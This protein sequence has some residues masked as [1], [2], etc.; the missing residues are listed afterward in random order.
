MQTNELWNGK[1]VLVVGLARSG[2][3]A[4]QLRVK[5]GAAVT[6]NDSKTREALGDGLITE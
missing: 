1:H 5:H 2:I 4:A 3:A 6:V